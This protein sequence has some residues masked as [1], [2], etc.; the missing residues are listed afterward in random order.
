MD[1][2]ELK[3]GKWLRERRIQ[4]EQQCD[5]VSLASLLEY[6]SMLL[7]ACLRSLVP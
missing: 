5:H 4:C 2:V 6:K 3:V 1:R 7:H